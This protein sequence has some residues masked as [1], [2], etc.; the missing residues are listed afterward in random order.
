LLDVFRAC[1]GAVGDAEVVVWDGDDDRGSDDFEEDEDE[2]LLLVPYAKL[3]ASVHCRCLFLVDVVVLLFA[4]FSAPSSDATALASGFTFL[5]DFALPGVCTRFRLVSHLC[6]LMAPIAMN[7]VVPLMSFP[8][9]HARPARR[10]CASALGVRH[11]VDMTS[12]F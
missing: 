11:F 6:F 1:G 5:L 8:Q 12:K 10:P 3:S 7:T 9:A 2:L 4:C